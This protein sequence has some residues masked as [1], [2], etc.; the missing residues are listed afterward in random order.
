[1]E[2]VFRQ[3]LNDWWLLQKIALLKPAH[4]QSGGNQQV[5]WSK[6]YSVLVK[7]NVDAS[8][9]PEVGKGRVGVGLLGN[10]LASST[11]FVRHVSVVAALKALAIHHGLA[12][13]LNCACNYVVVGLDGTDLTDACSGQQQYDHAAAIYARCMGIMGVVE[14]V[15]FLHV[16]HG[17]NGVAHKLARKCF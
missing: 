15:E 5:P 1:M 11:S 16:P 13:A 10:F 3:L 17:A 14:K 4:S 8:Y 2:K 6:P 12:L 9:H 7:V